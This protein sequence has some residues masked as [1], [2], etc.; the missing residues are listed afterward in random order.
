MRRVEAIAVR[1]RAAGGGR[2]ESPPISGSGEKK[3][4]QRCGA[5][6][7]CRPAQPVWWRAVLTGWLGL[8]P[9]ANESSLVRVLGWVSVRLGR[10]VSRLGRVS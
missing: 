9:W 2:R 4:V 10:I 3:G 7:P 6:W 1:G 5:D 8:W